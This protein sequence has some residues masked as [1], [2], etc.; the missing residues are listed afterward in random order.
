MDIPGDACDTDAVVAFGAD[1]AC[2]VCAVAVGV[3]WVVVVVVEVPATDIVD[4]TVVVVIDSVACDFAAVGPDVVIEVWVIPLGS[5][6][7]DCDDDAC[8]VCAGVPCFE[9]V[10]VGVCDTECASDVL[11]GVVDTPLE[12]NELIVWLGNCVEDIVWLGVLN[13]GECL[14]HCDGTID[15]H[16]DFEMFESVYAFKCSD[17]LPLNECL[18]GVVDCCIFGREANENLIR[19]LIDCWV[20]LECQSAFGQGFGS[21]LG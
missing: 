7:D 9:A 11:T 21:G 8:S 12:R 2:G 18:G 17:E 20:L 15:W 4:V 6:V 16:A 13:E 3:I 19:N 14:E 5:A 1:G 10:D